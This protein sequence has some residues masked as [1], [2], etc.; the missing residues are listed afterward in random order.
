M[1]GVVK[2][3]INLYRRI[4][5]ATRRCI[6]KK[7]ELHQ[8]KKT[9]CSSV[10]LQHKVSP[11]I[12]SILQ[13]IYI[14]IFQYRCHIS[15]PNLFLHDIKWACERSKNILQQAP[16]LKIIVNRVLVGFSHVGRGKTVAILT[17]FSYSFSCIRDV[18]LWSKSHVN[19]FL[20]ILIRSQNSRWLRL[21]VLFKA[22]RLNMFDRR[23]SHYLNQWLV[24]LQTHICVTRTRW[25][26]G[27]YVLI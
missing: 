8:S 20:R 6:W 4:T 9:L 15:K 23:T 1:G 16:S 26:L 17:T 21:T 5:T 24:N 25:E 14:Q 18:W 2:C 3:E 22:L 10:A 12:M 7:K 27:Q 13:N 11:K 19:L